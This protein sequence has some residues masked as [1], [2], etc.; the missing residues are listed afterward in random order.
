[1]TKETLAKLIDSYQGTDLAAFI[2]SEL[3]LTKSLTGEATILRQLEIDENTRHTTE[4]ERINGKWRFL[5]GRC[6]HHE[7]T[8]FEDAVG[9]NSET[10]CDLCGANSPANSPAI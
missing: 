8:C 3:E 6:P 1:M 9:S 10:L 4:L 2:F 5:R 7:C